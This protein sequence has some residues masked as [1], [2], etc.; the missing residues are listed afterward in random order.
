M[1]PRQDVGGTAWGGAP[2]PARSRQRCWAD[3]AAQ[4][5]REARWSYLESI[6]KCGV[7]TPAR[8]IG[9]KLAG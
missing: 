7:F 3:K 1:W 2:A 8:M 6:T 5:E 4:R 9:A